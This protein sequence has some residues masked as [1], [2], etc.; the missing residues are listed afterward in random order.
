MKIERLTEGG[1]STKA[2][3]PELE[4]TGERIVPGETAEVLF[5]QHE[6]RYVFAA[7]YVFGK[8]VLDIAC[9]TGVGTSYLREVGARRVWGLDIDRDAVA[10]ARARYANCEFAQSDATDMCLPDSSV[11]VVVSFETLEHLKDH[12]KFMMECRR[13][14]KPGAVL[15]C[16]TPNQTVSRWGKANPYHLRELTTSE[17]SQLLV[18]MFSEVQLYGQ[19]CKIYPLYIG[20]KVLLRVLDRLN[21]TDPVTRL[22]SPKKPETAIRRTEF[23]GKPNNLNGEIQPHHATLLIQ[24]T[25]VIGVGRNPRC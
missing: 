13:V 8:D 1:V 2:T 24:P 6:E 11:D 5:R 19:E 12:R 4:F 25:F 18:S 9:G 3:V 21:I 7:Q 17:F 20:R 23:S 14:L 16:S 10:F 15:I 22:L